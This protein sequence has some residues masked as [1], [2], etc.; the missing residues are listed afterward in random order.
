MEF[1]ANLIVANAVNFVV[2]VALGQVLK[3][4]VPILRATRPVLMQVLV[5]AAGYLIPLAANALTA[6]LGYPIDFE[7]ILGALNGAGAITLYHVARSN[8]IVR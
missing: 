4:Y 5:L 8:G 6:A 7:P 3:H 1:D 2:L